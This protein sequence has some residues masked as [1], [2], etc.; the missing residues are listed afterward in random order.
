[1]RQER[2]IPDFTTEELERE[3]WRPVVGY[4]QEYEVSNLGRVRSTRVHGSG[5]GCTLHPAFYIMKG[6]VTH[7]TINYA[8]QH[9][10]HTVHRSGALMVAEAFIPNPENLPYVGHRDGNGQNNRASNLY[11]Y[12][13]GRTEKKKEMDI[14]WVYEAYHYR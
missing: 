10:P 6:A 12:Q 11:W 1:M 4:Q 5:K 9:K 13:G 3:E 7:N 14:N 2:W 8:V